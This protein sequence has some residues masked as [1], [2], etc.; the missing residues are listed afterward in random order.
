M[1]IIASYDSNMV[2]I[3]L[4]DSGTGI[5]QQP[6][7]RR[8]KPLRRRDNGT[9]WFCATKT[10]QR[11]RQI[12]VTTAHL[13]HRDQLQWISHKLQCF[14]YAPHVYTVLLTLYTCH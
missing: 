5:V 14:Y 8:K 3:T 12:T 9:V 1:V 2:I 7:R 4:S 13:Q 6:L 11:N 10:G